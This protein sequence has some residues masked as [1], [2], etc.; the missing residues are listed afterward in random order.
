MSTTRQVLQ[1]FEQYQK[2]RITFVQTVAELASR[3]QNIETLQNAGIMALLRPLLLDVVPSIQQ[4]A[5][6]A[7]GRLANHNDDLA[8]AIVKGDILPQLVCSLAEQ[9]RFYK[10]TAA[11]VLRAV[12][13]HSPQLAQAVVDCGALEPLVICLEEFDPDVKEA[14]SWALGYIARHNAELA[15]SIVDAGAVPLLILSIQ[16]PELPLKRICASALSDIC[17]HS[18]ELAQTVVDAGAIAHLSQLVLNPDAKLKRQVFSALSQIAKHSVDLAEMVVEAEIFPFVLLSLKDSDEYVKK[19]IAML[20]R[21]IVKHTPELAQLIVNA[22]GVA[23]IVDYIAETTGNTRLPG[24]MALGYIAAHSE[25]LSM[26]VI[27]SNGVIQLALVLSEEK[28]DHIKAAAAWALGQIGRHT[29]EHAKSVAIANVLPK[30][31]NYYLSPESSEDLQIK[32][33]KALKN[34]LQ[35]C[36]HL[37]AL[38]PLLHNAPSNILKYV[39]S[40]FSKVLP[41][42]AKARKLFVTS[43]GLKKIQEIKV[44]PGSS[45]QEYVNE[46]NNCYP[47]EIV[48]YYSPGYSQKLLERI[49]QYQPSL[50]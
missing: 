44:E 12:A 27:V 16:E 15:Q 10:K 32:S 17:K 30:L 36:I 3:P 13:K 38:E 25:N 35:R 47:E 1:V 20:V 40:Q 26:A 6:L 22:G 8:E 41:H 49:E 45:L 50:E 23:A 9:N 28:E 11:F 33:K 24:I 43:G 37:P 5:A 48:R 34:I 46:I 39:V 29:P 19:N 31:L 7:L 42:D 4:T 14:A 21:E 2:S 18:P